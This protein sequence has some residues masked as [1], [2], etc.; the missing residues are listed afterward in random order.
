MEHI[1]PAIEKVYK[2]N[3]TRYFNSLVSKNPQS[4]WSS[5]SNTTFRTDIFNEYMKWMEPLVEYIKDT[6]TCGH[7]HERSITFFIHH[8][9][10]QQSLTQGWLTHLQLDSH[11]TQGHEVN[12]QKSFE[13]LFANQL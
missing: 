9:R 8:R 5:T 1:I 7:A 3:I 12:N 13:K 4:V 6:K 10:K 11:K 2:F